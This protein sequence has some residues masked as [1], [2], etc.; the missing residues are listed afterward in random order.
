MTGRLNLPAVKSGGG[1]VLRSFGYGF[2]MMIRPIHGFHEMKNEGRGTIGAAVLT[3]LLAVAAVLFSTHNAGFI[4]TTLNP[5][6]Y[7]II[8]HL[9]GLIL[10][11]LLWCLCNWAV[12]VLL[13]GEGKMYYI[14]MAS[15]YALMPFVVLETVS[16]LL[17]HVLLLN[18]QMFLNYISNLALG[19]SILLL[20]TGNMVIHGY[21]V[22]RTLLSMVMSVAG[23]LLIM[24]ISILFASV[25]DQ[26]Y[27]F[28][29]GLFSEI[30]LRM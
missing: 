25:I 16:V 4:F 6:E 1:A 13:D 18:E 8:R 11:F 9:S 15:C 28:G 30:R 29:M 20:F 7:N 24:F 26:V 3:G 14:F 27:R 10:P 5:H 22:R 2:Y 21:T 12:S 23:I 19:W 17:S